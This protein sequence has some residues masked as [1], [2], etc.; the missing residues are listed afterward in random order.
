MMLLCNR[1]LRAVLIATVAATAATNL[2]A[3][4]KYSPP[5]SPRR[6]FNF[7]LGWRFFKEDKIKVADASGVEFDDSAWESVSTPH[8]FNDTDSFRTIISHSGGDRGVW[9]GTAWYRKHFKLPPDAPRGKVLLEF[10]GFR[11]AAEIFLNGKAV[12]LSENGITAYGVDITDALKPG[13]EENVLAVHVDNRTDYAERATGV[14][15][16]WNVNDFNPVYGG[17]KGH[18]RLHC[19][20]PIYQTLPVYDGLQ[21]TGDIC[22]SR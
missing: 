18:V 20:G 14:R 7:D 9:K 2:N 19:L 6:D 13:N 5:E 3:Q 16:E 8:T 10:D 1:F 17:I 15:F 22:L 12:G 21:T 4:E 11:Q